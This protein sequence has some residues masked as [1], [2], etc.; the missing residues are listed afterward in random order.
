VLKPRQVPPEARGAVG[1]QLRLHAPFDRMEEA[2]LRRLVE[3]LSLAAYPAGAVILEPA[4]GTPGWLYLV[5]EGAVLAEAPGADPREGSARAELSPGEAFPLGALLTARPVLSSY[6]AAE[7]VR[8]YLLPAAEFRALLGLSPVFQDFCTRRLA[9]LLEQSQ[10]VI[11]GRYAAGS[12]EQQ[13]LATRLADLVRRAPVACEP[14]LALREA[15]TRMDQEGIGSMVVVDPD[16]AP[17]GIFT[18]RDLLRVTAAG[19]DLAQPVGR[20]MSPDP[21]SLPGEAPAQEAALAMARHGIR[22]VLVVRGPQLVGI[23]S[24]KDLFAL[25]QVGIHDVGDAIDRAQGCSDLQLAAE[26]V[27]RLARNLL[28]QGVAAEPLMRLVSTL[29]DRLTSRVVDLAGADGDF[30]GLAW[31]WLA[32]GSEGRFEQTLA[33]D[34]DNGIVFDLPPGADP[35]SVRARL[36]PIAEQINLEL[37]RCGFPLCRGEVMAGNPRW[38]LSLAEWRARF[39]DWIDRGDARDLLHAAIFFDFRAVHGD[40]RLAEALR[41]WLNR[42][43][44][45]RPRFLQQMAANALENR[46]PLGFVRDFVLE[47]RGE[48][49]HTVNLKLSGAAPFVDAGRIYALAA[50]LAETNTI[51]RLR[52]AA[53]SAGFSSEQVEAWGQAFAFIQLLRLRRQHL[54]PDAGLDAGNYVNPDRLNDLDRRILKESFRQARKLQTKLALDYRLYGRV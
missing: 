6:R 9:H 12:A 39:A 29:N 28:A 7:P 22:H 44:A 16:G 2:H 36:L 3:H 25:R 47:T 13:S 15:L 4:S 14:G 46:P 43:V 27:R 33:T 48:H 26:G 51:E 54:E 34:Q 41:S 10:R 37:D 31:C 50:G 19:A 42:T 24:E 8:C 30:Q 1:D 45:A 21:V 53:P 20:F 17:V 5:A 11:Q 49:P 52:A 35:E 32:L 18:L 40:R 23:V 38:C